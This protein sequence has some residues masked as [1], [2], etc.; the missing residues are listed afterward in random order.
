[1]S[2]NGFLPVGEFGRICLFTFHTWS[3]DCIKNMITERQNTLRVWRLAPGRSLRTTRGW[4]V[5]QSG[6][7]GWLQNP[8]RWAQ[9]QDSCGLGGNKDPPSFLLSFSLPSPEESS[10]ALSLLPWRAVSH[11]PDWGLEPWNREPKG[12]VCL[13]SWMGICLT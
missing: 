9:W 1:M 8:E 12:T 6:A 7:I 4:S 11:S 10:F 3:Y 5:P 13:V 2:N